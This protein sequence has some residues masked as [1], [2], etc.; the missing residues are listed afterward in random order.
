MSKEENNLINIIYHDEN[1]IEYPKDIIEDCEFIK[2]KTKGALILTKNSDELR[3]LLDFIK[4]SSPNSKSVLI[5]NGYSSEKITS[6]IKK[7]G[8][9]NLFIKGIIYS[10]SLDKY[11][12]VLEKNKDF[13]EAICIKVDLIVPCIQKIFSSVPTNQ[14]FDCKDIMNIYAYKFYYFSLH[15]SISVFYAKSESIDNSNFNPDLMKNIDNNKREIYDKIYNF[16]NSFKDKKDDEF[17]YSYLKDENISNSIKQI[18]IQRGK[19]DYNNI[20]YLTGNLMYRIVNYGK[21][22]KKG[23]IYGLELYKGM[24]LNIFDLFEFIKNEN[25]F[26][27]FSHFLTVTSKKELAILNSGRHQP[28]SDRNNKNLFSVMLHI[29]YLY[30]DAFEPCIFDLSELIPYPDDEEYI[31]LPF[32]FFQFKKIEIDEKKMNVDIKLSVIGKVKILEE[33]IKQGK[34]LFYDK[35]NHIMSTK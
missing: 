15:Q 13:I 10:Q 8:Y 24:R 20:S 28:L 27:S 23:V 21:T 3:L 4:K 33:D 9:M 31:V 34:K 5:M 22:D 32:T 35:D 16:F 17:I 25:L 11:K 12:A 29:E 30:D 26:L 19:D 18:L 2:E 6:F 1:F 14:K 7:K